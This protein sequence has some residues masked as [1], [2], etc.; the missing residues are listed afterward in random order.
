MESQ[1]ADSN[2]DIEQLAQYVRSVFELMGRVLPR[3]KDDKP[4]WALGFAM[5]CH[6]ANIGQ[7]ATYSDWR[8]LHNPP[9]P[10]PW[11]EH[12]LWPPE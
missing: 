5:T 12:M 8:Q 1:P 7:V 6:W 10:S 11:P 3:N 9:E 2:S 4:D